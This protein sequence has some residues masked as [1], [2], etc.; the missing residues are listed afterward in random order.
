MTLNNDS[1]I[2]KL[3]KC[4]I[5]LPMFASRG[6]RAHVNIQ[7]FVKLQTLERCPRTEKNSW[8]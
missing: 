2:Y 1:Y 4:M 8:L 7:H 5:V 3:C 6:Q